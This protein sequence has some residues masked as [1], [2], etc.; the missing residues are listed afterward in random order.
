MLTT[1]IP[2]FKKALDD[3][4][5]L[6]LVSGVRSTLAN[7]LALD[8]E[9]R[10]KDS[11]ELNSYITKCV[12]KLH[13]FVEQQV[14]TDDSFSSTFTLFTKI[15]APEEIDYRDKDNTQEQEQDLMVDTLVTQ[16]FAAYDADRQKQVKVVIKDLLS[17]SAIKD[18]NDLINYIHSEPEL[19]GKITADS[20]KPSQTQKQ[21][22]SDTKTRLLPIINKT[23]ALNEQISTFKKAA[24][25]ITTAV[26]ILGVVAAS[27][28]STVTVLPLI[29]IPA[30]ILSNKIAP[31][32]GEKI[33]KAVL[34]HSGAFQ[35]SLQESVKLKDSIMQQDIT[36]VRQQNKELAQNQQLENIDLEQ[37]KNIKTHISQEPVKQPISKTVNT[38]DK[39]L[40]RGL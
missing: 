31:A 34:K 30:L 3:N 28:V 35:N 32:L 10:I 15:I 6:N 12:S 25:M 14:I 21:L 40:T 9:T 24:S 11:V 33:G 16:N 17:S 8:Y 7:M 1:Y 13:K 22:I 26:C 27:V 23:I 19:I 36:L 39:S 4:F 20:L 5:G 29:T 37:F 18:K 2:D 38:P